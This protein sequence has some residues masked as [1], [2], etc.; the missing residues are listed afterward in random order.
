MRS[1]MMAMISF[2]LELL[3]VIYF[4]GKNSCS[5]NRDRGWSW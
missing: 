4:Q 1:R 3:K 2:M 5:S